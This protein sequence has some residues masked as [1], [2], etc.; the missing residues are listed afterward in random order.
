MVK[1][2]MLVLAVLP[3]LASASELYQPIKYLFGFHKQYASFELGACTLGLSESKGQIIV[4][5]VADSG[6][7]SS[8]GKV[9]EVYG[10]FG[11]CVKGTVNMTDI[12]LQCERSVGGKTEILRLHNEAGTLQFSLIN[13][14]KVRHTYFSRSK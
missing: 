1:Q 11:N 9:G 8:C 14:G 6:L 5:Y 7:G 13:D 10:V 3:S 2:M 12:R 4:S